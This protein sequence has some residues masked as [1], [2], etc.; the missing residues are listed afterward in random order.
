M[1]VSQR[2]VRGSRRG[3]GC[4]RAALVELQCRGADPSRGEDGLRQRLQALARRLARVQA[5]GNE[6]ARVTFSED[7]QDVLRQRAPAV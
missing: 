4:L 1:L 2:P 7:A 3:Q 6:Y 5:L